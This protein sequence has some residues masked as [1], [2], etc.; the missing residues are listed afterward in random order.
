VAATRAKR[1]D[2][3]ASSASAKYLSRYSLSK[4]SESAL[5][6]VEDNALPPKLNNSRTL[7]AALG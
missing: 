4:K 1:I 2:Q 3:T 5:S 7:I 6:D